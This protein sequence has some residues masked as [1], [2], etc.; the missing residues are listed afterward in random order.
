MFAD[1]EH[2]TFRSSHDSEYV[3]YMTPSKI[4]RKSTH[5]YIEVVWSG[6]VGSYLMLPYPGVDLFQPS[7]VEELCQMLHWK[8]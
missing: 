3:L 8:Q 2:D 7:L 5:E 4:L 6:H 1:V